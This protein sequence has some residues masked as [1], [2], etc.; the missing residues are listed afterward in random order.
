MAN[1]RKGVVAFRDFSGGLNLS[2]QRQD[3]KLNESPDCLDVDFDKRGGFMQRRGYRNVVLDSN[4]NGGYLIGAFSFGTDLLAG[5]STAGRLWTWDGTTAVHVATA[6]TDSYATNTV[7]MVPYTSKLYFANCLN[8]GNLVMRTW[9]G[10]VWAT[11]GNTVNN[12]YSSPAGGQAPLSR[13]ITD[14]AGFMWWGDTV[15][16]GTRYRSRIRFSHYLQ[17]EDWAQ[18]DYYDLDPDDQTDQITAI[19]PFRNML[20]VFKRRSVWGVYGTSR[21]DFVVERISASAGVWTQEG[22][23]VNEDVAYWWSPDGNLFAYNGSQVVPIGDR[24][25]QLV[26]DGEILPGAD[27]RICWAEGRL[28]ASLVRPAGNR[29]LFVFDPNIGKSGCWTKYSFSCSSMVWHRRV[30]G[31]NGIMMTLT[32]KSGVFDYNIFTQEQDYDGTTS[33]SVAAYYVTA[34]FS[35]DD[36]ALLKRF[37]R[38]HLT[39][40]A[41]DDSQMNVEVFYDFNESTVRRTLS[42]QMIAG[43][44][45]MLWNQNWGGLWGSLEPVYVFDRLT[46]AGRAHAIK[47]KFYATNHTSRWWVDSFA[48]PYYEKGYR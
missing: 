34:W 42:A 11:L 35:A 44:G 48:L 36:P 46:S 6:V 12:N 8:A 26:A 18:A 43:A 15:E 13:L 7:R 3:L 4:M 17:P 21:D 28:Y 14:H 25:S 10:T 1:A 47:F 29:L 33:T 38:M 5:I 24:I 32:A 41:R 39:C 9:N 27:H 37:R 20:L 30:A 2:A 16:G 40:A 19:V 45:G 23:S 31:T 22:V